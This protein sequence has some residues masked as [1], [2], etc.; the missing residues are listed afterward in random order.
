MKEKKKF[1]QINKPWKMGL[2][3]AIG[4]SI[5]SFSPELAEAN[6]KKWDFN[7]T[8]TQQS[9]VAPSSGKYLVEVWGAQ[10]GNAGYYSYNRASGTGGK[11][12][13]VSG[14]LDIKSKE[15]FYL[16]VGGQGDSTTGQEV[17]SSTTANGGWNGGGGGYTMGMTGGG[18]ATDIRIGEKGLNERL[19]VA[20]GGGGAGNSENSSETS[21][22]GAGGGLNGEQRPFYTQFNSR[23]AGAGGGQSSGYR[24]GQGSDSI[25]VNLRG[26]G[27]GGW[28]GA[29]RGWGRLRRTGGAVGAGR[30]SA[31][32][33]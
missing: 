21:D 16:F 28:I 3:F 27:G 15:T 13:Y 1:L 24:F 19:I 30:E 20:G 5:L 7:Y 26:A 6:T 23:T 11:G 4:L 10:G 8:G 9:W 14:E 17:T 18:G 12:G 31:R 25:G 32:G 22:G 29:D 2:S 33:P